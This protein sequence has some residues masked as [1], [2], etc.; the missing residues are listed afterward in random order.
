MSMSD[1]SIDIQNM[2]EDGD[3]PTVI[4]RVLGVPLAWVYNTLEQMDPDTIEEDRCRLA[5]GYN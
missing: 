1:I 5:T 4:A 2:L 3:H